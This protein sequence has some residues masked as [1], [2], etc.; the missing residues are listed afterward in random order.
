ML[1]PDP[2][3]EHVV[4]RLRDFFGSR[5]GW[6]RRLWDVGLVV[7]LK[8]LL[9][10]SEAVQRNVLSQGALSWLANAVQ[11]SAGRDPGVGAAIKGQLQR[12]VAGGLK[13]GSIDHRVLAQLTAD[14][15]RGYLDRL[16]LAMASPTTR[17]GAE[18]ASRL[19]AAHMLDSGLHPRYLYRWL[20]AHVTYKPDDEYEIHDIVEIAHQLVGLPP[21][22]YEVMVG[23]RP[24]PGKASPPAGWRTTKDVVAWLANEGHGTEGLRLGGGISFEIDARDPWSAAASVTEQL[25]RYPVADTHWYTVWVP[26]HRGDLGRG[27]PR[28]AI[29]QRA[30]PG[31]QCSRSAA[32]GSAVSGKVLRVPSTPPWSCWHHSRTAPLLRRSPE[33]GPPSNRLSCIRQT[34]KTSS[35]P[36]DSLL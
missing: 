23:V 21:R 19:I 25:E 16:A 33:D 36:I 22:T 2:Y 6:Q 7:S 24:L 8:E 4:A 26:R 32:R 11:A 20:D 29:R 14:V 5:A 28:Q 12:C 3:G 18:R 27:A 13:G 35:L 30:I 1:K 17:I 9:E 31:G 15:E 34:S 10:A